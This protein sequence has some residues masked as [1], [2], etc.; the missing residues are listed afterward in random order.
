MKRAV[1]IL[2]LTV[3]GLIPLWRFEAR[4]ETVA[5]PE[6][7]GAPEASAPPTAGSTT[8]SAAPGG[9]AQTVSGSLVRTGHGDV[10][11]QVTFDG[12]RITAVKMLKQPGSA[13]TR[14]AVPVLVRETLTAQSADVDTVSGATT[15]S[16]AYVES[17]QAAIDAKD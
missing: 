4:P 10:Q 2:L 6:A 7:A 15:T 13:P 12:D 3:A 1:P 17:L 16:E 14:Q 5:V 11:V 8:G 9:N